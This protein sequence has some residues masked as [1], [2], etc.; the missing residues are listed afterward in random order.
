MGSD[1]TTSLPRPQAGG[2][3]RPVGLG[4]SLAMGWATGT[5]P[6]VPCGWAGSPPSAQPAAPCAGVGKVG[7]QD[8]LGTRSGPGVWSGAPHGAVGARAAPG[9]SLESPGASGRGYMFA[10]IPFH[11]PQHCPKPQVGVTAVPGVWQGHGRGGG[12]RN[13]GRVGVGPWG[14]WCGGLRFLEEHGGH[15][16]GRRASAPAGRELCLPPLD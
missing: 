10:Q 12:A 4:Q 1:K 3:S 11:R 9:L 14:W 7:P 5:R 6:P 16:K 13:S 15:R 2:R 8:A